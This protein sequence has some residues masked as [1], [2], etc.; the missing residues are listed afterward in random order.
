MGCHVSDDN[1]ATWTPA[2][3][4]PMP[5]SRWDNPDPSY[6]KNWIVWQHPIRDSANRWLAGYT[7]CTSP[8]RHPVPPGGWWHWDSRCYFMRFDNIHEGPDPEDVRIT[9]LP[10][11]DAGI[12]VPIPVRPE[13]SSAQEPSLV[14]LPDGRLFT[15]MRTLTGYVWYSVSEDDGAHWRAPEMLRTRD[16]GDGMEHPLSCCPIYPMSN[17][18]YLLLFHNNRGCRL[19]HDQSELEW[20]TNHLNYIRNPMFIAVGEFRPDAHQPICFSE[21][22]KLLDTDDIRVGPKDTAEIGTYTSLTEWHGKRVLWYPDRKYYLLGK[23]LPD[24]FIATFEIA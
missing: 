14:L 24:E 1:G 11:E 4:I 20:K 22:Y 2:A 16:G 18:R 15:T 23:Y 9:W 13:L 3:D 8:K 19:G 21:P 17:G 6:P 10:E 12:E 7:L 5:R